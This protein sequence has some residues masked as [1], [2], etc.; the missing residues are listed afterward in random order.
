M[1]A[2]PVQ[3]FEALQPHVLTSPLPHHLAIGRSFAADVIKRSH[4]LIFVLR[5]TVTSYT[6]SL[7][8][9]DERH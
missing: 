7:Y 2:T 1:D 8:L 5:E 9:E 6:S 4:Q 3:H